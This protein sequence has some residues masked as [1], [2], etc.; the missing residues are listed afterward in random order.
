MAGRTQNVRR[1]RQGWQILCED[2][3]HAVMRQIQGNPLA[4]GP[5]STTALELALASLQGVVSEIDSALENAYKNTQAAELIAQMRSGL[6]LPEEILI[7]EQEKS[8][9]EAQK[10]TLE[11]VQKAAAVHLNSRRRMESIRSTANIFD[12]VSQSSLAQRAPFAASG[13]ASRLPSETTLAGWESLDS[14]GD[15]ER[16]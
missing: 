4:P 6:S 7:T 13:A 9:L 1:N 11:S 8:F 2:T 5:G 12:P 16:G 10:R 14:T 3:R 15:E